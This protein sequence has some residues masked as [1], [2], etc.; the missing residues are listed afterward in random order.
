MAGGKCDHDQGSY[1]LIGRT[2]QKALH[3][4][5]PGFGELVKS[6]LDQGVPDEAH[7]TALAEVGLLLYLLRDPARPDWQ[8]DID[9]LRAHLLRAYSNPAMHAFARTGPA[10]AL[11]GQLTMRLGLGKAAESFLSDRDLR[12]II[13]EK[14]PAFP[15]FPI[16]KPLE[17]AYVLRESGLARL[18]PLP[19]PELPDRIT[20][21]LQAAGLDD[22]QLIYTFTHMV[23]FTTGFGNRPPPPLLRA[24]WQEMAL[25]A[26]DHCCNTGHLDLIAEVLTV[27]VV[28]CVRDPF[29]IARGWNRLAMAQSEDGTLR[30]SRSHGT[31]LAEY[32]KCLVTVIAAQTTLG[33]HT[34]AGTDRT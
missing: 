24:A 6:G 33:A 1:A 22:P 29:R 7:Q 16:W 27:T 25:N 34:P 19:D 30:Q 8:S 3:W 26:L 15:D 28:L 12:K 18:A 31:T 21:L 20:G 13:V 11:I 4:L 17:M 32:H 14:A 5:V 2:G 10:A 9:C 23:F